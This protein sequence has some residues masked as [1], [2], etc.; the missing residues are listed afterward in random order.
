MSNKK[1]FS[2]RKGYSFSFDDDGRNIEAWFSA[3]S[4]M[5]KVFVDGALISSQRTLSKESSHN[6][7]IGE[8]SYSTRMDAVSLFKGPFLC[9]LSKNG[10]EFKRQKLVYNA[11][12][13]LSYWLWCLFYLVFY[14]ALFM[15]FV[16]AK[17]YWSLPEAS[18]IVF[19]FFLVLVAF[20]FLAYRIRKET[21]KIEI[22]DEEI[23]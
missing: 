13:K 5:E 7:I 23:I 22:V 3:L 1:S 16:V 9:T 12:G 14:F 21:S 15:A 11:R 10:K 20:L 17:V 18:Y 2:F 8:D 19:L 6:F 4:G